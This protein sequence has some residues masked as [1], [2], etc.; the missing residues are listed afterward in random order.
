MTSSRAARE[1]SQTLE[2]LLRAQFADGAV[3]GTSSEDA[4]ALAFTYNVC[5]TR[6][7]RK[8]SKRAYHHG[9]VIVT[10][11]SCKSNHLIADHLG[12][13]D[14]KP[15]TI[16]SIM[17]EKGEDVRRLARFQLAA[18][19]EAFSGRTVQVED[20]DLIAQALGV[21]VSS[22]PETEAAASMPEPSPS[23]AD[24]MA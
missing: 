10:C 12:W 20:A 5:N 13:F 19:G 1:A 9:V 24:E 17:R 21:D 22:T 7:A 14:D 3:P 8:I 2:D 6:S 18:E 11:P 23:D 4:Y 16:E 15:Q